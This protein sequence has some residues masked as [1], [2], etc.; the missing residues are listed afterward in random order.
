M[1]GLIQTLVYFS[2]LFCVMFQGLFGVHACLMKPD[3]P[4]LGGI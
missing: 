3:I 4:L 1:L 2:Y